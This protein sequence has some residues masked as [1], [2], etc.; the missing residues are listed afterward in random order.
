MTSEEFVEEI[1]GSEIC[2]HDF[3]NVYS[4]FSTFQSL[5]LMTLKEFHRICEQSKI[6]Y[7]LAFGSL[8]GF[9]RDEGQIPWDY[10]ADVI[11]PYS[12]RSKLIEALETKLDSK[13]YFRS[14]EN[15]NTCEH[16]IIRLFPVGYNS[17]VLHLDVF[18][19]TGL[20]DDYK[21]AVKHKRR[22]KLY[23]LLLKAKRFT[24]RNSK[25]A[26]AKEKIKMMCYKLLGL[27]YSE[28]RI[29]HDYHMNAGKFPLEKSKK[30]CLADRMNYLFY[31]DTMLFCET[32]IVEKGI[33]K[34]RVPIRYKDILSLRYGSY[35][36]VPPAQ[37]RIAELYKNYLFFVKFGKL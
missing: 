34:Y 33:G 27:F 14:I 20:P 25:T 36:S 16:V 7:Q 13:Y 31:Y 29:I 4:A 21:K 10:D 37:E 6:P 12:Y 32:V 35:L 17:Q 2:P 18:F 30:C 5:V 28:N 19:L 11:V 26:S 24:S 3:V 15:D 8:L 9:I 23:T 1:I 22:I